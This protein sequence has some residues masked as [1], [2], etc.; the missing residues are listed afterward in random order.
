[1]AFMRAWRQIRRKPQRR[2]GM[3]DPKYSGAKVL[4]CS[5]YTRFCL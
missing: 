5:L 1:M 4:E 3:K 2:G